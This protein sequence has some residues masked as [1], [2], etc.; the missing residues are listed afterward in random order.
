MV[1]LVIIGAY[2][3]QAAPEHP[4]GA[5]WTVHDAFAWLA[6]RKHDCRIVSRTGYLQD[7][8][9]GVLV[10]SQPSD[11]ELAQHFIECDVMVT[12]LAATMHAQ[13]LAASYQTPLVQYVHSENQID[14]LGVTPSSSALVVF[15]AQHVADACAWW[16]GESMVMRPPINAER[17]RVDAP[18][19]SCT[20][21]INLS[22]AKGGPAFWRLAHAL[23][24]TPFLGVQGAYDHQ[25]LTPLGLATYNENEA[26]TG[27]PRNLAVIG[28]VRDIRDALRFTR[29][30]LVLS[31]SETYGRVAA[32]AAASGIPT[33]CVDTP[34]LRECLGHSGMY[35]NRDEP[36]SVEALV[37]RGYTVE[38]EAWSAVA[39]AQWDAVLAAR[40][41]K[42]LR[43]FER[44]LRRIK[45]EQPEMTL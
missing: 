35:M 34:G 22:N 20:T 24:Q 32:E 2:L 39:R 36:G 18:L 41:E 45:K 12:Q 38:W 40:Q 19:G 8:V 15:N 16:P 28:A 33:I 13:L 25:A 5:E 11:D 37:K 26:A 4:A 17:V 3:D 43:A 9:D 10:Y 42:E 30:L 1:A 7:R 6:T 29:T 31:S 44:A 21:L 14:E 23:E 27:L